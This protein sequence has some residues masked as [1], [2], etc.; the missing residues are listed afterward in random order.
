MRAWTTNHTVSNALSGVEQCN[1]DVITRQDTTGQQHGTAA[2]LIHYRLF[3]Q[4]HCAVVNST[5]VQHTA[6][7]VW[8]SCIVK[9]HR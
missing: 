9:H 6:N 3:T 7:E 4:L 1:V 8:Q 2:E 5:I